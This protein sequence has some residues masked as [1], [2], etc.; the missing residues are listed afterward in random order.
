MPQ[1]E[2]IEK[3]IKLHGRRLD[4]HERKRKKEIL[5]RGRRH[6]KVVEKDREIERV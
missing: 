1:N 2:Y 3:H 4:Y 5:L 6:L